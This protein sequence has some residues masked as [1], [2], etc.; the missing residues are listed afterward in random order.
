MESILL[1]G[2]PLNVVA[3]TSSTDKT[4]LWHQRM[5]HVSLKG[6]QIL[7]KLGVLCG[8]KIS[9][10]EFCEHCVF[11]EM[12]RVKFSTRQHYTKGILDY[13]HSDLWGPSRIPLHGGNRYFIT[14]LDDYS[15]KVW[16]YLLKNKDDA[17]KAFQE[18]KIMIENRTERKIKNMRTDNGLEF[19]RYVFTSYCKEH[20]IYRHKTVRK[21]PQ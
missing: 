20:G 14:F 18:W 17:F 5:G 13:V 15:R 8:D 10:L 21:T 11:G 4:S 2:V 7:G 6:L 3:A 16:I 1:R 9:D 12:H 19:Y